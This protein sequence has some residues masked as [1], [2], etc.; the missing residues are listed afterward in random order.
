MSINVLIAGP[1]IDINNDMVS[2]APLF[3]LN[4]ITQ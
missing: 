1:N 2:A 3:K 4:D